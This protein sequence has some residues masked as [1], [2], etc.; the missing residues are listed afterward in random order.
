MANEIGRVS[1][2]NPGKGNQVGGGRNA[3]KG[4]PAC[5]SHIVQI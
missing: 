1:R 5:G 3:H 2:Y 4:S